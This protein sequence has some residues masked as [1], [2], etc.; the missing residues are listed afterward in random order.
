MP[1]DRIAECKTLSQR[2]WEDK[3][4]W[5]RMSQAITEQC[6]P[7]RASYTKTLEVGD[8]FG[9]AIMDGTTVNAR[10]ELGNTVDAMLRQG[11]W[12]KVGTGDDDRDEDPMVARPLERSTMILKNMIRDPRMNFGPATKEADHDY[13]S[14]GQAVLTVEDT[15]DRKFI[16]TRAWHPGTCAWLLDEDAKLL[17]MFRKVKVPVHE[18]KRKLENGEWNGGNEQALLAYTL[19]CK[20]KPNQKIEIMHVFMQTE[21]LYAHDGAA[22]RKRQNTPWM[23]IY[24]DIERDVCLHERGE[25]LNMYVLP[26]WRSFGNATCGFSPSGLNSLGDARMLQQLA[27]MILETAEKNLDP[28]MVGSLEVFTRDINIMSGGFTFIDLPE[29]TSLKDVMT[30]IAPGELRSGLELKQDVRALIIEAW[31]LNKLYLPSAR[32]MRELEV[33]VRTEEFRRAALPF[34]QP[35]ETDYHPG[36]LGAIFD[37]AVFKGLIPS[38]IFPAQ[39]QDAD[40]HFTFTSPLNEAEGRKVVESFNIAVTTIAAGAQVDP[41]V[42]MLFDMKKATMDAVRG[43]GAKADWILEGRML[44]QRLQEAEQAT[45]LQRA[46]QI[47]NETAVTTSNVAGAKQAADVSGLTEEIS[48]A[49]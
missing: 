4:P 12:F 8:A 16:R 19:M 45:Q 21:M 14:V 31:L 28:P 34:F 26:R 37:R 13:V 3:R 43:A 49:A 11:D 1:P 27:M 44:K 20:D 2:A 32:E 22:M 24:L 48:A 23:S 33:A 39:L 29:D 15:R 30:T 6:Y 5:D 42:N 9:D 46:A 35:I 18:I 7:I 36:L 47:A 17:A 25:P 41:S 10:E 38:A 40:V